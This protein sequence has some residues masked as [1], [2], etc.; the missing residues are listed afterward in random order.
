MESKPPLNIITA[1]FSSC[2]LCPLFEFLLEGEKNPW[3]KLRITTGYSYSGVEDKT[4]EIRDIIDADLSVEGK[5]LSILVTES[6]TDSEDHDRFDYQEDPILILY[7]D[8]TGAISAVDS[9]GENL[10][11]GLELVLRP[12]GDK[13][14]FSLNHEDT[15][16]F[17]LTLGSLTKK[18]QPLTGEAHELLDMSEQKLQG[19]A[20]KVVLHLQK[21]LP[22]T[23]NM[24][25]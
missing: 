16:S 2:I 9:D 15:E 4:F 17:I 25:G 1:L 7:D 23:F 3:E 11:D 14:S 13:I 20:M 8:A 12:E 10:M 22:G 6:H 18:P 5:Q 19:L 21:L 24:F